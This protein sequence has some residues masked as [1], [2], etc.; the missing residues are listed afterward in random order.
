MTH[1]TPRHIRDVE[2]AINAAQVDEK[3]IVC[4]ILYHPFH[5]SIVFE[6]VEGL[7]PEL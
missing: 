2:Q 4:N 5:D 7:F 3:T 6:F 1:S